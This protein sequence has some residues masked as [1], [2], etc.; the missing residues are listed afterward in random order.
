VNGI[1]SRIYA[2]QILDMNTR[3]IITPEIR[4]LIAKNC[5][6]NGE[7]VRAIIREQTGV[8]VPYPVVSQ[9]LKEVRQTAEEATRAC[10]AH[11]SKKIAERVDEQVVPLM[12]IMEREIGRIAN[13]LEGLDPRL[14]C[15][16]EFDADGN[17]TGYVSTREYVMLSK[18]LR[19][20][21]KTYVQL[22]P[23]VMT[24]KIDGMDGDIEKEFLDMCTPEELAI[25]EK[26]KRQFEEKYSKK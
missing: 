26:L 15:R 11:I 23:Q 22:R 6:L 2:K 16:P 25:I 8:D 21:I 24:V 20:N 1:C 4:E 12:E 13:A 9:C 3:K 5:S 19:E 18:E 17:P 14:R 7:E 10:D